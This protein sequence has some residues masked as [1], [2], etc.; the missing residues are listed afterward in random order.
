MSHTADAAIDHGH[1]EEYTSTGI[2]HK[3]LC[4]W[5]FLASDCMSS[6]F[7]LHASYLQKDS[8]EPLDVTQTSDI[9]LT[10]FSTFILLATIANGTSCLLNAK[11]N[12]K[13]T[14]WML[15]GSSFLV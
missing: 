7:D 8:P 9:P 10:S 14:R 12:L 15:F 5:A 1:H 6:N 3:K 13:M 2:P 11:A 4:M